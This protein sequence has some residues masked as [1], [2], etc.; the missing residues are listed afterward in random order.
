[1]PTLHP[2]AHPAEEPP[3]ES[4]RARL[5][6]IIFEASTPAGRAFDVSLLVAILLSVVLVSIETVSGLPAAVYRWLRIGEW[7]LTALFTVE[8]LLRLYTVRHPVRYARS[9]FGVVDLLAILPTYVSLLFPG[10]QYLLVVRALRLLRVFRVLK[11]TRFLTEAHGLR[12][13]LR[14]SA[15]KISVFLLTVVA[16]VIIVGSVMYLVEGGGNGFTSIPRS[17]YWTVVTLTTVGYGDIA[18]QTVL[19]QTLASFVM[20]LGYGIIAVPTGIVTVELANAARVANLSPES[21]P[22]CGVQGHDLDARF[23]KR[24]GTAL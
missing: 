21:C 5:H 14:A 15:H 7:L 3:D 24:C 22:G 4:G 17:M 2:H 18:P 12:T 6:E 19:G 11:L 20:V 9:F 1:M 23:C 10:A 13:A 16:V 8:Y